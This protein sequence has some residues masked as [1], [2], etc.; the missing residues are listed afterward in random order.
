MTYAILESFYKLQE[1][2][3]AVEQD[4]IEATFFDNY[5]SDGFDVSILPIEDDQNDGFFY[6]VTKIKSKGSKLSEDQAEEIA[7]VICD[8]FFEFISVVK[9]EVEVDKLRDKFSG[10]KF[11]LNDNQLY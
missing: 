2:A 5:F 7:D 1:N 4:L 3:N 6:L 8:K 9:T 11:Y 10:N